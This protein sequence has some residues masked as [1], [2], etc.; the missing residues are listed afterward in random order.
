MVF[1]GRFA[2]FWADLPLFAVGL[3]FAYKLKLHSSKK[4][5]IYRTKVVQQQ[6]V[7]NP[8]QEVAGQS[9]KVVNPPQMTMTN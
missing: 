2:S 4:Y 3:V 6:K 7:A 5:I 8:P 1:W 9:K